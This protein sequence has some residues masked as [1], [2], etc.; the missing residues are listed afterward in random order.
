MSTI[1]KTLVTNGNGP[2]INFKERALWYLFSIQFSDYGTTNVVKVS[3]SLPE[4]GPL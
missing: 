1:S 4:P 3:Y 2:S